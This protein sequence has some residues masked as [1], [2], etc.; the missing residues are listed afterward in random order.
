VNA[1][2]QCVVAIGQWTSAN[3]LKLNAEK[4]ELMWAVTRHSAAIL[5]CHYNLSLTVGED[6]VK[7]TDVIRVLGMLFTSDLAL[8]KTSHIRQRQVLFQL[9]QLRRVI[10]SLDRDSAATLVRAFVTIRIDYGNALLANSA[11]IWTD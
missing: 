10:R 6:A 11:N 7:A 9:R 3:K 8:A 1:L 2:V 5:F 4:T